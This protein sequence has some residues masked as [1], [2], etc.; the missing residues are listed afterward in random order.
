M[1]S[2]KFVL[3]RACLFPPPHACLNLKC[4]ER[5]EV[6][7]DPAVRV[8]F[9]GRVGFPSRQVRTGSTLGRLGG[10]PI[11]GTIAARM[12]DTVQ[13]P[14]SNVSER[15]ELALTNDHGARNG[16]YGCFVIEI[17]LGIGP[18]SSVGVTVF[19]D[20]ECSTSSF[21]RYTAPPSVNAPCV[22]TSLSMS[23]LLT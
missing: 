1:C 23:V 22:L 14:P 17:F 10:K 2:V 11:H 5:H 13:C 12:R 8:K 20:N 3:T 16:H 7:S 6:L 15:F 18:S 9:S 4:L 21:I 19:S